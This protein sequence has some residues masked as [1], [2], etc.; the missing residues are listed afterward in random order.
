VEEWE[1]RRAECKERLGNGNGIGLPLGVA[2]RKEWPT[3]T[4]TSLHNRKGASPTSG[5]GLATAVRKEW[6]TPRAG[7]TTDERQEAWEARRDA[8]QVSTPPLSLAVK[9]ATPRA[10]GFDAGAHRGT[11]DSLH[12]QVKGWPTPKTRDH[13]AEGANAN[14]AARS[15]SLARV[16]Q[17]GWPTPRASEWKGVGPPGSKS[18]QYRLDK[19]YLDATV[20]REE[21]PLAGSESCSLLTAKDSPKKNSPAPSVEESTESARAPAP[22]RTTSTSTPSSGKSC[23]PALSPDWVETLMGFP[24]GWTD[25]GPRLPARSSRGSRRASPPE[26]PTEPQG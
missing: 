10:E 1:R 21:F 18:E 3:V 24:V 25:V 23:T 17:K 15:P 19:G 5:D 12:A 16:I 26:S 14:P 22:P 4:V 11:P 7:K 8:G 2:V 6:P 13:H 20:Q 9:W